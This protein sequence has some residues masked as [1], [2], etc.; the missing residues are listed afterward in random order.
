[1]ILISVWIILDHTLS[2]TEHRW[3]N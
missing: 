2:R 3:K 1:M